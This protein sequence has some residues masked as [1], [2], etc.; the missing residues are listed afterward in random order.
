MV[1]CRR[2]DY[3][4]NG[5]FFRFLFH[6][7]V[8]PK[9]TDP[10]LGYVWSY[11]RVELDCDPTCR[12]DVPGVSLCSNLILIMYGDIFLCLHLTEATILLSVAIKPSLV[13]R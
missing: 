7:F 12:W 13:V 11:I 5:E 8:V 10:A 1:N 3:D 4:S 2:G 6:V 9:D